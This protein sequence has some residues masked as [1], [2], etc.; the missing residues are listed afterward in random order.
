VS[1]SSRES[2]IACL[3]RDVEPLAVIAG[4]IKR[5]SAIGPKMDQA[6]FASLQV[7]MTCSGPVT[8]RWSV[9]SAAGG[10]CDVAIGL[11]GERG[12]VTLF[13]SDRGRS[14]ESGDWRLETSRGEQREHRALESFDSAS[15]SIREFDRA[16]RETDGE[17]RLAMST[18]S[19]ATRAMEV[20]DAV[21]LSLEKGR[22]LDVHQQELTDRLAFRGTMSALGCG[23]LLLGFFIFVAVSLFGAAEGKDRPLLITSWPIILLALLAGFLLLQFAPLLVVKKARSLAADENKIDSLDGTGSG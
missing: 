21:E 5:V 22:T 16:V 17:R 13:A 10:S 14:K 9:G 23:L 18:W 3:A 8:V 6:S 7:Q 1:D 19:V 15:F 20:V 12:A 4:D 11:I 2:V